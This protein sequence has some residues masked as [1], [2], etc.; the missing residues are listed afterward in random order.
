MA[1]RITK[2]INL[3]TEKLRL[4]CDRGWRDYIAKLLSLGMENRGLSAVRLILIL[5]SLKK[6]SQ[7]KL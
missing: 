4:S 2:L 7:R 5:Y 6:K 1:G 3:F